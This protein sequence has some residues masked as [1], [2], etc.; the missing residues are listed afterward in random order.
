MLRELESK[1]QYERS[2]WPAQAQPDVKPP[3][4]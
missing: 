2:G 1:G 4:G 3:P